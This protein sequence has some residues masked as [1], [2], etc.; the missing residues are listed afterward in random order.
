M[1][2]RPISSNFKKFIQDHKKAGRYFFAPNAMQGF[3]SR[4]ED[5]FFHWNDNEQLF[6]TSEQDRIGSDDTRYFTVRVANLKDLQVRTIN[7]NAHKSVKEARDYISNMT[8]L[9][10][11]Y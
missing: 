9:N 10:I 2:V 1:F 7:Y 4:I 11:K 5:G 8:K 3:S 6:I